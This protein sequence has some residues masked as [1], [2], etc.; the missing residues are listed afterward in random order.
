M[1]LTICRD[2]DG[3]Y[4]R[5][6]ANNTDQKIPCDCGSKA[7]SWHGDPCGL[8]VY[9]CDLCWD[10]LDANKFTRRRRNGT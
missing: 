3:L 1:K 2:K 7:A 6:I 8:R 5:E 4:I 10:A 9:C